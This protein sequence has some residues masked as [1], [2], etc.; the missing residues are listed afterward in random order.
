MIEQYTPQPP[1][2]RQWPDVRDF[3]VGCALAHA[4]ASV[5]VV[6]TYLG[7]LARYAAWLVTS[8]TPLDPDIVW[9]DDTIRLYVHHHLRELGKSDHY[10]YRVEL[11]LRHYEHGHTGIR[12][13][14][15][16]V[17]AAAPQPYTARELRDFLSAAECAPTEPARRNLITALALGAGAG[18]QTHEML[19]ITAADVTPAAFG[20]TVQVRGTRRPRTIPVFADWV[21][22]LRAIVDALAPDEYLGWAGM[23]RAPEQRLD[24]GLLRGL[25]KNT[26]VPS[27]LRTTWI[28]RLLALSIPVPLILELAGIERLPGLDPYYVH[29]APQE[30][31]LD[32]YAAAVAGAL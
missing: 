1:F 13:T 3:V 27:R 4:P 22:P 19:Q 17:S 28:V 15:R 18:L 23:S 5:R 2:D 9:S 11:C 16:S 12:T 7:Y 10:R 8:G 14:T 25:G 6:R 21:A 26:P 30:F 29:V 20:L 24:R 31:N 32:N